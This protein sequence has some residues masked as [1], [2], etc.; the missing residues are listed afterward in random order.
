MSVE[1]E[2]RKFTIVDLI[3]KLPVHP[4]RKYR[5][6][7]LSM[8]T[9]VVI[10]H[11][12]TPYYIKPEE[13]ARFHVNGRGWPGI[14]YHYLVDHFGIIYKCWPASTVT[15]CVAQGNVPSL[16]V[17]LIGNFEEDKPTDK[18]LA[19]AAWLTREIVQAYGIKD[20]LGHREVPAQFTKCPGKFLDMDEFR[21]M[22]LG[23]GGS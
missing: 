2:G 6:R 19:A 20:V 7:E 23:Q 10:H 14:G 21:R 12:A 13:I 1:D 18:Q 3:G 15:Y 4:T 8:I 11:S 17:C 5:T 22:V 9:R 16:C